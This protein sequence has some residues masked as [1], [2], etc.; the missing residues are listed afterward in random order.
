[1][2]YTDE[3][4]NKNKRQIKISTI[5]IVLLSLLLVLVSVLC[6]VFM[7]KANRF[8]LQIVVSTCDVLICFS[9]IY[10]V[11]NFLVKF[12]KFKKH[13]NF[14]SKSDAITQKGILREVLEDKITLG[15]GIVCKVL[16]FD[17]DGEMKEFYLNDNFD[18]SRF[19]IGKTYSICIVSLFIKEL[20]DED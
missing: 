5:L 4:L 1:M 10:V 17:I 7:N 8:V 15:R 3:I 13:F 18:V 11:S 20:K 16:R 6:F 14:I 12:I 2:F 19:A 9:I